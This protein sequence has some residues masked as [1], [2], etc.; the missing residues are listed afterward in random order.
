MSRINTNIQSMVASRVLGM[1]N[2]G[3][4]Q[5]LDRLS[6]GLRI[7]T[8]KDDPAGLIASERLRTEKAAIGAAITNVSRANIMV[9][10][11]EGGLDETNKLLIEMEDLLDRS[12]NESAISDAERDA[13]QLQIDA[14]LDSI[15]RISNSTEF[16]GRKLLNGEFDYQLSNVVGNGD[17]VDVA[18]RSTRLPDGGTRTVNVEVVTSA[19]LANLSYT[20]SAIH[21]GSVTLQVGGNLGNETLSFASGTTIAQIAAAVNQSKDLT[22]VSATV[23]SGGRLDF[24]SISFGSKQ[25]VKVEAISGAANFA[26]LSGQQDN[27]RDATVNVDGTIAQVDGLKAIVRTSVLDA[28]I[29]LDSSANTNG[30]TTS[31]DIKGGGANFMISPTIGL[32]GKASLGVQSVGTTSLGDAEV[33]VLQTIASGN[34][35]SLTNGNFATAQRIIRI[36]QEQVAQLRGRLGA[37]QKNTLETTSNSLQITL[38]NTTAAESS[39]RDTDFATETS[40]LTRNQILAQSATSMLR[41]ANQ[42]PQQVLSLLG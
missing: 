42:V 22:G 15:N 19:Q 11:L 28:Q 20:S 8:G 16:L 12:A 35:N 1:Q 41:L 21:G 3:L 30:A 40:T 9:A 29:I 32:V 10:T 7:N 38:E 5:S 36:A 27:G 18:V 39:I 24:N 17:L 6:T 33:G 26:A 4:A 14:I 25:F 23:V 37:F 13:N 34:T 31:F 2:R